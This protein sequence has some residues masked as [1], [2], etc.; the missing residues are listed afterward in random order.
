M[1]HTQTQPGEKIPFL[2]KDFR[3]GGTPWGIVIGPDRKVL[4]NGY[5]LDYETTVKLIRQFKDRK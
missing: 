3:T 5:K 1:G 4:L 2:M